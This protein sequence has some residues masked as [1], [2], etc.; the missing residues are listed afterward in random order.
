MSVAPCALLCLNNTSEGG[1][2]F[3]T[4]QEANKL[5]LRPW[6]GASASSKRRRLAR[7]PRPC[8]LFWPPRFQAA[9]PSA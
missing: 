3:L 4:L 2:H 5:S 8:P 6:S 9:P 7:R 1:Q